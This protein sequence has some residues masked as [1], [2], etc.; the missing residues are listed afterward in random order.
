MGLAKA[1]ELLLLG[2]KID[3]QT[4]VEWNICSRILPYEST[5]TFEHHSLGSQVCEIIEK[6]LLSLP[7]GSATAEVSSF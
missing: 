4:A 1:N 6:E 5:N 7:L 2:R 3:A